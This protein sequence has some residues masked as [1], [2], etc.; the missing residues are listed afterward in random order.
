MFFLLKAFTS[1]K[2]VSFDQNSGFLL[3]NEE[4]KIN[5]YATKEVYLSS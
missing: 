3:P 2:D 5:I 1:M 4:A